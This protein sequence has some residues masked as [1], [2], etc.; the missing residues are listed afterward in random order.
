VSDATGGTAEA[1]TRAALLQFG[2][3][4]LEVER[5]TKVQSIADIENIVRM[6]QLQPT[7]VVYTLAQPEAAEAMRWITELQGVVAIDVLGPLLA[8][9]TQVLGRGPDPVARAPHNPTLDK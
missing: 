5:F 6:A 8:G 9:L 2:D 4:L 3:D 7:L 1:A